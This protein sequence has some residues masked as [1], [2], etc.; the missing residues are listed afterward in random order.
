[1]NKAFFLFIFLIITNTIFSQSEAFKTLI[2]SVDPKETSAIKFD[3]RNQGIQ[4]TSWDKEFIT[5]ELE[6]TANFPEAVLSQ[7]LQVGRYN[8]LSSIEGEV[9]NINV[10]NLDQTVSVGGKA[11]IDDVRLIV[12]T[13]GVFA[14][15]DS[16]LQKHLPGELIGQIIGD[17]EDKESAVVV[18]DEMRKIKQQIKITIRFVHKE[19]NNIKEDKVSSILNE[20]KEDVKDENI[21]SGFIMGKKDALDSNSSLKD[22][23]SKFGDIIM[24]GMP[25]DDFND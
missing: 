18:L 24:G 16:L 12:Q 2:K 4:S 9:F 20:E 3:F 6:V 1:M 17:A 13:P 8:I 7:L 15:Y 10:P 19:E 25:L 23:Q 14:L 21:N 5:I 11:L 22:V